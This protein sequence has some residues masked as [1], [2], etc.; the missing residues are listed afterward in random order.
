MKTV[1]NFKDLE[2]LTTQKATAWIPLF[3]QKTK[4]LRDKEIKDCKKTKQYK[5]VPEEQLQ[6]TVSEDLISMSE[7]LKFDALDW[8]QKKDINQLWIKTLLKENKFAEDS[9]EGQFYLNYWTHSVK[10]VSNFFISVTSVTN[11]FRDRNEKFVADT[12]LG[13]TDLHTNEKTSD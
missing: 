4:E 3:D 9:E 2:C 12:R 5:D 1:E 11:F 6:K 8:E 10:K 7:V 13:A